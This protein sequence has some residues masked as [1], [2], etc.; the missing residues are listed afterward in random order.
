VVWVWVGGQRSARVRVRAAARRRRGEG[1][2]AGRALNPVSSRCPPLAFL[3]GCLFFS[4]RLTRPC[5]DVE[6]VRSQRTSRLFFD[7]RA[8][9]SAT[10]LTPTVF[11]LVYGFADV[12]LSPGRGR[13]GTLAGGRTFPAANEKELCRSVPLHPPTE[14]RRREGTVLFRFFP[15]DREEEGDYLFTCFLFPLF[16]DRPPRMQL[17]PLIRSFHL[18]APPRVRSTPPR[19]YPSIPPRPSREPI[20]GRGRGGLTSFTGARL[21]SGGG[22]RDA[23][24][25][26]SFRGC[27]RGG[28]PS[29][30]SCLAFLSFLSCLALPDRF[31]APNLCP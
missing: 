23:S 27:L 6:R 16:A 3:L 20:K 18:S 14:E 1:A 19:R 9:A 7:A 5:R 11:F 25:R 8:L 13:D 4:P 26:F 17:S 15:P 31:R 22:S 12:F 28:L 30:L 2:H 21:L 29:F 10:C 24:L